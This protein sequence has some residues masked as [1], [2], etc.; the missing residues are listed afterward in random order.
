MDREVRA[1]QCALRKCACIAG[2]LRAVTAACKPDCGPV[3]VVMGSGDARHLRPGQE[4]RVAVD[5][6]DCPRPTSVQAVSMARSALQGE[7]ADMGAYESGV[8]FRDGF[9]PH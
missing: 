2:A 6:G 8:L 7:H 1:G 3:A 5:V 9:D 4:R